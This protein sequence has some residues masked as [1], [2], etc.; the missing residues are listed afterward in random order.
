MVDW[1]DK[2]RF[3][4][5]KKKRFQRKTPLSHNCRK[6]FNSF[7]QTLWLR[8]L[9]K[10]SSF[11]LIDQ[12]SQT[13][14]SWLLCGP[15]TWS[16]RPP[17]TFKISK[18]PKVTSFLSYLNMG[19]VRPARPHFFTMWPLKTFEFETPVLDVRRRGKSSIANLNKLSTCSSFRRTWKR[20]C[21]RA[22]YLFK[23]CRN[24]KLPVI[25]T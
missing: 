15:Q 16:V 4:P 12:G 2:K 17:T 25:S 6:I 11:I 7:H 13:G 24:V 23:R 10:N 9:S 19:F 3:R 20:N 18:Y 8:T 14:I 21:V 5:R 22:Y 1:K